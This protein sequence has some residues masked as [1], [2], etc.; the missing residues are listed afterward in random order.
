M[1]DDL[2]LSDS[3]EN[4]LIAQVARHLKFNLDLDC[5]TLDDFRDK[6]IEYVRRGLIKCHRVIKAKAA[7]AVEIKSSV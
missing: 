6:L 7:I 1:T 2:Y 3:S 5:D 4:E